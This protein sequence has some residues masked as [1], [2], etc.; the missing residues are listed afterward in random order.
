M[1]KF[2]VVSGFLGAGKTT[3][4]LALAGAFRKRGVDARLIANDLGAKNLV[5]AAFARASGQDVVEL[6]GE[7]I[8]YQ[9][10]NLVDKLRR[11]FDYEKADF[12]LSDIPGC[13]VGA[14]DHVYHKL[15]ACYPGEFELAPFLVVA[16]PVRLAGIMPG[17]ADL[18]L[19]EEMDYLFRAQLMEADAV[20][21]NKVDLLDAAGLQAALDFLRAF[22]P[23]ARVF[24]VSAKYGQGIDEVAAY[25][26]EE[27]A[28]L[29]TVDIG[30]GGEAFVAAEEKLSWYNRQLVA[31]A[32]NT[33]FDGNDFLTVYAESTRMLLKAHARNVPHM[34]LFGISDRDEMGKLSLLGVDY[35]LERDLE[36]TQPCSSLSVIVNARAACESRLLNNIMEAALQDAQAQ[37]NLE[38][39]TYFTECFGMMDEGRT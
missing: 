34:K 21:L 19:P 39:V 28:S 20:L 2:A 35:A 33:T 25:L 29:K 3:T 14:L 22:C 23:D 13:G 26:A 8:C 7:C 30:Y 12:V 24:P 32:G 16:D 15:E 17:K 1:K 36:L 10:E 5:D 11:F 38:S 27:Q 6:T 31:A 4:M 18:N 9:T 37:L